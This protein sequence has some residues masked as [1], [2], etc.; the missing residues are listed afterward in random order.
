MYLVLVTKKGGDNINRQIA[1]EFL[2]PCLDQQASMIR[3]FN[4]IPGLTLLDIY[5]NDVPRFLNVEYKELTDYIPSTPGPRNLKIYESQSNNLLL[6]LENLNIPGGQ[7]LTHAIFGSLNNLLYL[8]VIDDIN[9]TV[10]RD[11]A[12]VRFYNLDASTITL[13]LNPTIG[14]TSRAL[15]SGRGTNY[16]GVNPGNYSLEIRTPSLSIS[17]T[18][19]F[20]QGRIYT[21]YI[22]P[23]V[24][25]DSPNYSVANIPQVILVV[26]GNTLFHKCIWT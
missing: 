1:Y 15:A 3:T 14:L 24:S 22:I 16:I 25:P 17:L 4:A 21:V 11:Q 19:N 7:I 26:D 2:T 5:I 12:K 9:E 10:A 18:I 6:E 8:P 13:T 20:N 23:S